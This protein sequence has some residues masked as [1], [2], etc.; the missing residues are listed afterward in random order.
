VRSAELALAEEQRALSTQIQRAF[1]GYLLSEEAL[2]INRQTLANKEEALE[3][4]RRKFQ[5]GVASD[6]EVLQAEADVEAFRPTLIAAENQVN[7][8]LL[9][10]RNLLNLPGDQEAPVELVGEL[11]VR[12]VRLDRP[13]LLERALAGKY[14]LSALRQG[15]RLSELQEELSRRAALPTVSAF[16]GYRAQSGTDPLTGDNSWFGPD[17]WDGTLTAGLSVSVPVSAWAP[18]SAET[19]SRAQ[20]RLAAEDRR[21]SLGAAEGGVRLAVENALLTLEEQRQKIRSGEKNIELAERLYGS[22]REQYARGY[23]SSL[24]LRDAQLRLAG[25]RLSYIQTVY[26]WTLALIDLQDAVGVD[27]L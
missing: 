21:L 26:A 24:E 11:S 4:A 2:E 5:A 18:W 23:I 19:A 14:D 13:E 17:S 20:S 10:V 15:V 3:V 9:S 8:A 22:A 27:R 25:A 6:F 12:E 16:V 7:F 1:Y